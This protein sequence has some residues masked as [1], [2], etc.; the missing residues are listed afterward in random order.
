MTTQLKSGTGLTQ[1]LDDWARHANAAVAIGRTDRG[2]WLVMMNFGQEAPDSPMAAGSALG[3]DESLT[4]AIEQAL[5][6]ARVNPCA[7]CGWERRCEE[8]CHP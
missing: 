1:T 7:T 5:S 8:G 6:D 3:A 2:E 4:A